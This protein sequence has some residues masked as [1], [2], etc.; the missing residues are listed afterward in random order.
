M[1][2][3]PSFMDYHRWLNLKG[4]HCLHLIDGLRVDGFK[5]IGSD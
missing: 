5:G 3:P 1:R 2:T 4:R